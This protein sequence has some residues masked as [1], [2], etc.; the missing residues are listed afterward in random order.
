MCGLY[1]QIRLFNLVLFLF[2]LDRSDFILPYYPR[3]VINTQVLACEAPQQLKY[4]WISKAESGDWQR[5]L[6]K[7][8]WANKY[9][10][11]T[12]AL[13]TA[14]REELLRNRMCS[15][16]E[17]KQHLMLLH[18]CEPGSFLSPVESW[19]PLGNLYY[20]TCFQ[21]FYQAHFFCL[22]CITFIRCSISG[23]KL[24]H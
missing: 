16:T 23:S 10:K 13:L 15:L 22:C 8:C 14:S 2:T 20:L 9:N 21:D 17:M 3:C 4:S 19:I 7:S 5:Y 6:I 11:W 18:L 1:F 12:S 24:A